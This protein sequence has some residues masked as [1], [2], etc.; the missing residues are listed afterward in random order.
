MSELA[1]PYSGGVK[2]PIN[3]RTSVM[4]NQTAGQV[5]PKK[6]KAYQMSQ[7]QSDKASPSKKKQASNKPSLFENK[8]KN[9]KINQVINMANE[10]L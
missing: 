10:F 4:S 3:N 1:N 9:H 7:I 2:V 6:S 8:H 5:I